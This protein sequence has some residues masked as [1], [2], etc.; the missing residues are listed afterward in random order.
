MVLDVLADA[1]ALAALRNGLFA[2]PAFPTNSDPFFRSIAPFRR[3]P[4]FPNG[5]IGARSFPRGKWC[6]RLLDD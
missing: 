1:L 5:F 6:P 2:A 3:P 4:E